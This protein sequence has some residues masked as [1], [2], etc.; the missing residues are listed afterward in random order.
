MARIVE[1]LTPMLISVNVRYKTHA[2]IKLTG[3]PEGD[4]W[5]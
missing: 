4:H 2:G 3:L 5:A 1:T